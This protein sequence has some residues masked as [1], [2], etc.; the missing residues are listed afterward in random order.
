MS[1]AFKI[2]FLAAER[3][4]KGNRFRQ[5]LQGAAEIVVATGAGGGVEAIVEDGNAEC[6]QVHPQL[7]FASAHRLQQVL[8]D[9]AVVCLQ[10]DAGFGVWLTRHFAAAKKLRVIFDAAAPDQRPV[11]F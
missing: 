3:V 10:L 2:A 9:L 11:R 4:G 7:M 6:R 8:A 1:A 5:Q